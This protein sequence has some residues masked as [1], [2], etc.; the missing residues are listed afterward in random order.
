[1]RQPRPLLPRP[2]AGAPAVAAAAPVPPDVRTA[3]TG[4]VAPRRLAAGLLSLTRPGQWVK[5]LLVVPLAL[6][7]APLWTLD[8]LG[9]AGWAVVAFTVASA[10]VYVGNDVADRDRDRVHPVKR[11]RPVASGAVPVAAAVALLLVLLVSLGLVLAARPAAA[12][13]IVVYLL[14]N[15]AYSVRLKHVPLLD[16]FVLATGF[17]LRTLLGYAATGVPVSP[18]LLTCVLSGSL[19]LGLGKRRHE[20]AVGGERHRPALR[21]YSVA[22]IDQLLALNAALTVMAYLMFADAELG[23]ASTPAVLS[24]P[25]ALFG[26]SR[27]LQVLLVQRQGGNP[28]RILL[29]DRPLVVTSLLWAAVVGAALL[30]SHEPGA[31][32]FS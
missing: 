17:V 11:S 21:G 3:V 13:P 1:M 12:W 2:A 8:L 20:L 5:N 18:W 25:F 6:L 16:V 15:L 32:P 26:L 19:L 24:A 29:R 27:Y 22:L 14:V 4:S 28:L 7:S 23:T 9:D 31:L 30:V 10:A